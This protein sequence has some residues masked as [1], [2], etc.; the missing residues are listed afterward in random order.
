MKTNIHKQLF[1]V[2]P[3]KFKIIP[4][5]V[6]DLE[7]F[8]NPREVGEHEL[9][10]KAFLTNGKPFNIFL[11]GETVEKDVGILSPMILDNCLF[12]TPI[13][14]SFPVTNQVFFRNAGSSKLKW[15]LDR[16]NII[17]NSK[18]LNIYNLVHKN[19]NDNNDDEEVEEDQNN[20][21]MNSA[22]ILSIEDIDVLEDNGVIEAEQTG[23]ITVLFKPHRIGIV[24]VTIPLI[25][26]DI[27]GFKS[28]V[29]LKARC[30]SY[31]P[32]TTLLTQ[33]EQCTDPLVM[34]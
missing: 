12:P 7:I 9:V 31:N 2:K 27:N 6:L 20:S 34:K 18:N 21:N 13:N 11:K 23:F 22:N 1:D 33:L 8:Y 3:R 14:S 4:G 19:D 17:R 32:C 29:K 5:E 25:T 28:E 30:L 26:E 10:L 15:T 16:E 24:N